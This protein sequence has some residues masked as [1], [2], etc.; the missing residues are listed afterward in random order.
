MTKSVQRAERAEAVARALENVATA[1]RREVRDIRARNY[2]SKGL[3]DYASGM[4]EAALIC[5]RRA[6]G[7]R[8]KGK[9][10]R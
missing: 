8:R 2:D 6:A 1:I 3:E 7:V 5:A 4:A 10:K 9:A